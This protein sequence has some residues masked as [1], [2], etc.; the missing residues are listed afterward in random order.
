VSRTYK[1]GKSKAKTVIEARRRT[2]A[3]TFAGWDGGE[4]S[5]PADLVRLLR[6]KAE[7]Q[8]LLKRF[9]AAAKAWVEEN[10]PVEDDG[11]TWGPSEVSRETPLSMKIGEFE[12]LLHDLGLPSLWRQKLLDALRSRGIGERKTTVRFGWSR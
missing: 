3:L 2:E 4:I 6:A 12:Q 1:V 9:D 5:T 10:G 7:A 11:Q 8:R